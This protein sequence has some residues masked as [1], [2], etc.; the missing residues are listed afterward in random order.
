[1]VRACVRACAS[2]W[3]SVCMWLC[4]CV[5]VY[6]VTLRIARHDAKV[7]I[8][9]KFDIVFLTDVKQKKMPYIAQIIYFVHHQHWRSPSTLKKTSICICG[10]HVFPFHT[11]LSRF[12]CVYIR[13]SRHATLRTSE[14]K[15]KYHRAAF[16]IFL[17]RF[18]KKKNKYISVVC[19][20]KHAR[21]IT[22][23]ICAMHHTFLIHQKKKWKMKSRLVRT[24]ST[25]SG[26]EK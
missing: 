14:K 12:R 3:E 19:N 4:M 22:P 16:S 23:S 17:S 20:S 1:M 25:F 8:T 24:S 18:F 5:C 11:S 7:S 10:F 9:Q 15:K 2:V 21:H 13:R 26:T 6:S